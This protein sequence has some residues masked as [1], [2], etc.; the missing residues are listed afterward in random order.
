VIPALEREL[1]D[2][3]GGPFEEAF[4]EFL[5]EQANTGLLGADDIVAIGPWWQS[6]GQDQIDA[7]V[8]AQPA[9]TRVPVAVGEAKWA[10]SVDGS[11]IK[12]KLIVKA[13]ALTKDVDRLRYVVCARNE[14]NRADNDTI[15]VTA[16]DIFPDFPDQQH[17]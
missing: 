14:V 4:R 12:A 15:V 1:N 9:L 11:R 10:R 13:A 8:L 5:W 2:H 17:P 16:A 7:V 6:G 3:M